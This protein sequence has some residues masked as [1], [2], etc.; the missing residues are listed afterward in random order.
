MN[1]PWP[2]DTKIDQRR[3][4]LTRGKWRGILFTVIVFVVL[5]GCHAEESVEIPDELLGIW[6]PPP[7]TRYEGRFFEITR[8]MFNLGIGGDRISVYF[9]RKVEKGRKGKET[10]YT[11]FCEDLEGLKDNIF[12]YYNPAGGGTLRLKN[13]K[14]IVWRKE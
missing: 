11:L 2:E 1:R 7:A 8:L 10:L 14:D 4:D 5:L 13:P 6:R 9:V 3:D 12:L